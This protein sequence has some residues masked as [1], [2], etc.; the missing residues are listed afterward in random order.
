MYTETNPSGSAAQT[1]GTTPETPHGSGNLA[2]TAPGRLRVIKRN[3][4][5]VSF[6]ASKISVAITKPRATAAA[7]SRRW[8]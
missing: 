3:G 5:V 7:S 8:R 1:P 2:A 4:T 6:E